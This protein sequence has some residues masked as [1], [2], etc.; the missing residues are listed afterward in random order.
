MVGAVDMAGVVNARAI[1]VFGAVDMF[2]VFGVVSGPAGGVGAGLS[3][4]A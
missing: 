4:Q 3:E 2:G 1:G